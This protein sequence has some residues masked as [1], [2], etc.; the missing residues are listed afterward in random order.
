MRE[1]L[2]MADGDVL[3]AARDAGSSS[4]TWCEEQQAAQPRPNDY[5]ARA[6]LG[7][8]SGGDGISAKEQPGVPRRAVGRRRA[9][10]RRRLGAML[11]LG[12]GESAR[13]S[14]RSGK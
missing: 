11:A 4:R 12:G 13:P 2:R 7:L 1:R 3:A 10:A 5:D 9:R 14:S 8:L 6:V